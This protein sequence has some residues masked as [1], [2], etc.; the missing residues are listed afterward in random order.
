MNGLEIQ[1]SLEKLKF[2]S[3]TS[4]VFVLLGA[5]FLAFSLYYSA[6]RLAPLE[7]DI[8]LKRAEIATLRDEEKQWREKIAEQQKTYET[9]KA[10]TE[11]LYSVRVTPTN[12]VYEVKATARA[13]GRVF[14]Q[15][16][17]EY[18]FTL[19]I[20]SPPDTLTDIQ[21]VVYRM[22]HGTF[23]QKDYVSTDPE[24]QFATSYVGWGCLTQVHVSVK[25]KSGTVQEFDFN[26]CRSLGPQWGDV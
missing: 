16:R 5:T 22:E 7:K 26:M 15:N 13:T 10:S 1:E 23:K 19:L 21:Q 11:A 6:T 3:R 24:A 8:A 25:L 4:L 17:P 9:L 20:N 18:K 2:Q 12:K 14:S